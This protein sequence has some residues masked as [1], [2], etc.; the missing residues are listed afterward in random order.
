[1]IGTGIFL[2]CFIEYMSVQE[3]TKELYCKDPAL[4]TLD[5]LS[6]ERTPYVIDVDDY[7]TKL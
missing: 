2:T 6:C 3:S 4:P 7:K 1:M 5:A